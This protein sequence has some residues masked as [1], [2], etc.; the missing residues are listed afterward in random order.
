MSKGGRRQVDEIAD[1]IRN[2]GLG[3]MPT[4]VSPELADQLRD[5]V[6]KSTRGSGNR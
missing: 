1:Y 5:Y 2:N 3:Q 4:S 6:A